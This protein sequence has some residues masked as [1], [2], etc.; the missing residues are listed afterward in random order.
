MIEPNAP[1]PPRVRVSVGYTRN[2]GDFESLRYDVSVEASPLK[3]ENTEQAFDR[4]SD[5]VETK[6]MQK[7]QEVEDDFKDN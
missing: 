2:M 5:F 1:Q 4:I 3:G 6:L 7:L